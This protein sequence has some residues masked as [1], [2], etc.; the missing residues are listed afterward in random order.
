[1]LV[2]LKSMTTLARKLVIELCRC[3]KLGRSPNEDVMLI[4]MMVIEPRGGG[5]EAIALLEVKQCQPSD[6]LRVRGRRH[7]EL[8]LGALYRGE[9]GL[10]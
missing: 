4:Q 5:S 6:L 1:M 3:L 9:M 10:V 8:G 7:W 2:F